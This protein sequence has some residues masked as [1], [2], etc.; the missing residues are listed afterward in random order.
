MA[1]FTGGGRT[2]NLFT[3]RVTGT[4]RLKSHVTKIHKRIH[5]L[6]TVGV[7][8]AGR[9]FLDKKKLDCKMGLYS[10]KEVAPNKWRYGW[11]HLG[12]PPKYQFTGSVLDAHELGKRV[13]AD[14]DRIEI[15][16]NISKAPHAALI[17]GKMSHGELSSGIFYSPLLKKFVKTRPWM[18]VEE[19][20][21]RSS[22]VI[23]IK[24][25]RG[26]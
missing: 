13:N 24:T 5:R 21:I 16:L 11:E 20:E 22:I 1:G 7:D 6:R 23:L 25:Y 4:E 17:H 8:R 2:G 19:S 12:G 18:K 10:G 14:T 3:V 9:Y 15:R 26:A